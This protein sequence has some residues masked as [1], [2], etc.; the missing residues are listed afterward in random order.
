MPEQALVMTEVQDELGY[1][2]DAPSYADI[3]GAG[4]LLESLARFTLP[5]LA[6]RREFSGAGIVTGGRHYVATFPSTEIG[7]RFSDEAR[8]IYRQRTAALTLHATTAEVSADELL[9]AFGTQLRQVRQALRQ[10]HA[11]PA[12]QTCYSPELRW[13]DACHRYPAT[14][15]SGDDVICRACS[16][17]RTHVS[18]QDARL[19][20]PGYQ[21]GL[22]DA[23]EEDLAARPVWERQLRWLRDNSMPKSGDAASDI[24]ALLQRRLPGEMQLADAA[25]CRAV[26]VAEVNDYSWLLEQSADSQRA[27]RISTRLNRL[28]DDAFFEALSS[29]A[30]RERSGPTNFEVLLAGDDRLVCLL[31]A[32][33][34][35]S[36]AARALRTFE[37]QSAFATEGRRLNFCAGIGLASAAVNW[38]TT[39]FQA[40]H[41]LAAAR[42]TYLRTAASALRGSWRSLVSVEPVGGEPGWCVNVGELERALAHAR[43]LRRVGLEGVQ[44]L[45]MADALRTGSAGRL[46][47]RTSNWTDPQRRALA[48]VVRDLALGSVETGRSDGAL[49]WPTIATL[50]T[51][52]SPIAPPASPRPRQGAEAAPS[53]VERS[54]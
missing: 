4:A 5:T 44:L 26:I 38:S 40:R 49:L 22:A 8:R 43:T 14:Q 3:R 23:G 2:F 52:A 34:A 18:D 19:V 37:S 13:C 12:V 10:N 36:V 28:L 31:P 20:V 16:N 53:T 51:W 17:R 33:V 29:A 50:L 32:D 24:A 39:A 54:A 48:A 46:A 45:P 30:W 15:R 6:R 25:G 41:A 11:G 9:T 1:L 42:Q 47:W 7:Q 21:S 27:L 35:P